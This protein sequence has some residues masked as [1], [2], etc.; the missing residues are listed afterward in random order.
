MP[1]LMNS[2]TIL[3]KFEEKNKLNLEW[4]KKN[5]E[6]KMTPSLNWVKSLN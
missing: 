1:G 5:S 3:E 6:S 4:Y 2:K